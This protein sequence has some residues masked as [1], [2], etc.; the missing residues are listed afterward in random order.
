MNNTNV[1]VAIFDTHAQADAAVRGL[2]A[3]GIDMKS[4]S[5]VGR[6]YHTEEHVVGYFNAGDR[7]RFFGRLGAFWGGLAGMLFGAAFLF[8]PFVGHIVVLGPL[9]SMVVGARQGAAL[10]GGISAV[11]GAL[12]ALGIPRNSVLRYETA[13]KAAKFLVAVQGDATSVS[14]ARDLLARA[15]GHDAQE[16]RAARD[17]VD[18]RAA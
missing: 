4:I 13:I 8:V 16:H 2:A 11:A 18:A 10:G 12:S 3:A 7:A 6:D 5:I 9:A 15:G 1:A 17:A 14:R